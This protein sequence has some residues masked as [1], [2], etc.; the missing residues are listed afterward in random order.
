MV[1]PCSKRISYVQSS[2]RTHESQRG[3]IQDVAYMLTSDTQRHRQSSSSLFNWEAG[4]VLES[5]SDH[6][7]ISLRSDR[8]RRGRRKTLA[9]ETR[10]FPQRS[11]RPPCL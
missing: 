2:H 1:F 11:T 10:A 3:N 4:L 6:A 9:A 8:I 7:G 5:R